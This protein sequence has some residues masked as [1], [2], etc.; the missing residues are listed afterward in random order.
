M[1]PKPAQDKVRRLREEGLSEKEI[2]DRLREENYSSSRVI[3]LLK[4][5]RAPQAAPAPP[6]HEAAGNHP[7][8][9][10]AG[11]GPDAKGQDAVAAEDMDVDSQGSPP[12]VEDFEDV[13]SE[14]PLEEEE[15]EDALSELASTTAEDGISDE[16][17]EGNVAAMDLAEQDV[18][19][20]SGLMG[21]MGDAADAASMCTDDGEDAAERE[22]FEKLEAE[23]ALAGD[24][25]ENSDAGTEDEE[26]AT[27]GELQ[28]GLTI[29]VNKEGVEDLGSWGEGE[30]EEG[31]ESEEA[32]DKSSEE[33]LEPNPKRRRKEAEN[34]SVADAPEPPAMKRPA[35]RRPSSKER[36][37][38]YNA[39]ACR[40]NRA[41]PGA[42]ARIQPARKQTHCLFC[43]PVQL[44]AAS[45][46]PRQNPLTTALKKFL[47]EDDEDVFKDAVARIRQVLGDDV[48]TDF[49]NRA[50][51]RRRQ[52]RAPQ[53]PVAKWEDELR[54]RKPSGA[55]LTAE[56][57]QTYDKE[58]QAD[59]RLAR[60]K[61]FYPVRIRNRHKVT[62]ETEAEERR[63]VAEAG[64]VEQ[65]APNDVE[66]PAPTD[67]TQKMI[68]R[69]CKEGSWAI[70]EACHSMNMRPLEPQD[71][72][73]VRPPTI[74]ASKCNACKSG[75]YIPQPED[76]PM[77]LRGLNDAVLQALRPLDIDT[78][79]FQRAEHGYRIHTQMI[80]FAWAAESV[81]AKIAALPRRRDR[82]KARAAL[83]YLLEEAPR[84]NHYPKFYEDH[85]KFLE[86]FGA[87]LQ[88]SERRRPLRFIETE[89]LECCLWPHLYWRGDLCETVVRLAHETRQQ[90]RR[91][92]ED[93]DAS[94]D[95]DLS[96]EAQQVK[97]RF[98]RIRMHFLR[99]VLSPV[100]GYGADYQLL[101]FVYDLSM[102]T[103]IGTK[104]NIASQYNVQLRLVLKG[105]PWAPQYW[106]VCHQTVIDVQRQ[107]GNARM[108]RTRAPYERTFPYHRWVMDEQAKLGRRRMHLAG[109][110]TLHM[111]HVLLQLDKGFICGDKYSVNQPSKTWQ[112]HLLGCADGTN[113]PTVQTRV[114]RLE[115][116]DGKRKLAT[117]KYHG[118]GTTHSHSL[119]FLQNVEAIRLQTKISASIPSAETE[120]FLH[121]LV[122]D[123]QCDRKDSKIPVRE[124]ASMWDPE[125]DQLLLH[126]SE[127]D[128]LQNVRAYFTDTMPITK[129]HEDIQQG[130]GRRHRNYAHMR[131]V[132]T[133][134]T[135]F[136]SPSAVENAPNLLADQGSVEQEWL[137]DDASD[138]SV[139]RRI[140]CGNQPLEP[141]MWMTLAGKLL[142]QFDMRGT[143]RE[144][145][146]PVPSCEQKPKFIAIYE[147]S[148][149][150]PS[151]MTLLEFLRKT[152]NEGDILQHIKQ[153]HTHHLWKEAA[154]AFRG[155]ENQ[156]EL[157]KD[158]Q[159]SFKAENQRRKRQQQEPLELFDFL[160]DD[161]SIPVVT[162]LEQFA[163]DYVPQGEKAIAAMVNSRP[164]DKFYGQ[165][166]VLNVPFWHLEDFERDAPAIM[167]KVPERYKN[168]ALCLHHAPEFWNDDKKIREE[169][170]CEAM[171]E[172][173]IQTVLAKVAAQ[174]KL[175]QRYLAGEISYDE[176]VDSSLSSQSCPGAQQRPKTKLT[177]SQKR[178]RQELRTKVALALRASDARDDNEFQACLEEAQAHKMLFASGPPGTGKTHVIHDQIDKWRNK[179]ARVLFALPTGML[180]SEIRARQPHID[181][182]TTWGAF[183]FDKPLQET[184]GVMT[185]YDLIVIDEVS[186]LTASQFEHILAL[187]KHADQLP[188]MVLLG[189]FYQL[190]VMGEGAVR[191]ELSPAWATH[192][193]TI[194]FNEQVRCKSQEL[195]KKLNLL[196]TSIPSKR[197]VA[198]IVKKHR[199]WTTEQPTKYDI[200]DLW[201][202]HPGTTVVTCTRAGCARVNE[203]AA[204]VFFE[205]RHKTP[206]GEA[207]LDY[208]SNLDNYEEKGPVKL[209]K[210]KL[211]PQE[212]KVYAGMRVFLT[213]N[214]SKPDDF[215]NGMLAE[216]QAYDPK[217]RCLE[218]ITRTGKRLAVYPIT[219]ELPDGGKITSLP[220]RLGYACT[221][222][223]V[224]GMTLEHITLWLDAAGCRAAAYVALSRVKNDADYLIGGKVGP[225][226]FIPAH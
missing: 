133:Y 89:G 188:A 201:R 59:Q 52:P 111:A 62:P 100:V 107:C 131:Y 189:D 162:S 43:D 171:S 124:E 74:P 217:S 197:K 42:P 70:C 10:R 175:I 94:D 90:K 177:S 49:E 71:T 186:M 139:T 50:R 170:E 44:Q 174:R 200:L 193:R 83:R 54:Y 14:A 169:M 166:L 144:I 23:R 160:F 63:R 82:K 33:P 3:Q 36:C 41:N 140:L 67:Q 141:E 199:A 216:V 80:S 211:R 21:F 31:E 130:G 210:G 11:A 122:T 93:A 96:P 157:V 221:V 79:Y 182:D 30:E 205:E 153:K 196:R 123:S 202:K 1:A 5:T 45:K 151:G 203:L 113:R 121:G 108:F 95:E 2:R 25:R 6:E 56:R 149:W 145:A 165:W 77:K 191:C 150:R 168:F 64:A 128:K 176:E 184:A 207:P 118:R 142:P 92:E 198:A 19:E 115:F 152:N 194:N 226:H 28:E 72:R 34:R 134:G 69:W 187:W 138:F 18:G 88:I 60:R 135:K 102:W 223:K 105:C 109:P 224:Q 208:E 180:A 129:C 214:V 86:T 27:P 120:P 76:V 178:L 75:A 98:G 29:P 51:G 65:S 48:A 47:G 158:W 39:Q 125:G 46:K 206:L 213:R 154:E 163:I 53:R 61:I 181:V 172:S 146:V 219:E 32:T 91:G 22:E 173:H 167:E 126:H 110:E 161:D 185:Q 66:L 119:D 40:F 156:Q 106:R 15:M 26:M 87:G 73:Q 127:E 209:K 116:Q 103:T 20:A 225:K 159:D 68:E 220:V 58:V 114:T 192:V 104:K 164:N 204:K 112:N 57:R 179:G 38:G 190:P 132:A 13:E 7:E 8:V 212:T 4:M 37:Q 17:I 147:E 85:N 99:K 215:V 137:N 143:S 9:Q 222:P 148:S 35:A 16:E 136:S 24:E 78:G 218:V 183:R 117:Q 155:E 55:E 12:E 84:S 97:E 195:Q 81:D 101:H